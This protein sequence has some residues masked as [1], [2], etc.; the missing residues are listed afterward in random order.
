METRLRLPGRREQPLHPETQVRE[1]GIYRKPSQAQRI[2]RGELYGSKGAHGV[3]VSGPNPVRRE[4]ASHYNTACQHRPGAF[5]G[6]REVDW[7]VLVRNSIMVI[8][9][10]IAKHSLSILLYSPHKGNPPFT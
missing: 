5:Y 3:G 10:S 7:G 9:Y 2:Q 1:A 4:A 8:D 6:K